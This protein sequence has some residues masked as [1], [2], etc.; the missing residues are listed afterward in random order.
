M[1]VG[2]KIKRL[3]EDLNYTQDYMAKKTRREPKDLQQHRNRQLQTN[4]RNLRK[5]MLDF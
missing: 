4:C 2:Y 5:N 3:R 1:N